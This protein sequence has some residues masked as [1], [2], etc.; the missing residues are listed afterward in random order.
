MYWRNKINIRAPEPVTVRAQQSD[1]AKADDAD[2][3]SFRKHS[4]QAKVTTL[5]GFSGTVPIFNDVSRKKI[6]VL[7]GRPSVPFLAWCP[8]FGPICPP[9]QPCVYA[10]VAKH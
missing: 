5:P 3:F 9:L 1:T 10:S 4:L 8:G 7:P 2:R 6:T